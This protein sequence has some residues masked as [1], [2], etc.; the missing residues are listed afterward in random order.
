MS[1]FI[2][3]W[4]TAEAS[5]RAR[6]EPEN[7]EQK[8]TTLEHA[9]VLF[10]PEYEPHGIKMKYEGQDVDLT[11]EQVRLHSSL[12]FSDRAPTMCCC[13]RAHRGVAARCKA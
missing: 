8:W 11:P 9:G 13:P 5:Q 6:S 1:A 2:V 10:P 12:P 3:S 4:Q 7:K